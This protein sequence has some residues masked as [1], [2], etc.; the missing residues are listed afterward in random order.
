MDAE[1]RPGGDHRHTLGADILTAYLHGC[2]TAI[3][4]AGR[5]LD[6]DLTAIRRWKEARDNAA[7]AL[8]QLTTE[9]LA[10]IGAAILE[11][12]AATEP[13]WP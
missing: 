8:D 4:A 2:D 11:L 10:R 6:P 13:A 3:E 12:R 5:D 9:H 1:L 7:A